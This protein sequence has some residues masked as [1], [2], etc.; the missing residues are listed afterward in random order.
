MEA[1]RQTNTSSRLCGVSVDNVHR[2][3]F[4]SLDFIRIYTGHPAACPSSAQTRPD[5]MDT[6]SNFALAPNALPTC[7]GARPLKSYKA[8]ERMFSLK[9]AM[10]DSSQLFRSTRY[11]GRPCVRSKY[12]LRNLIL[13][14]TL[15]LLEPSKSLRSMVDAFSLSSAQVPSIKRLSAHNLCGWSSRIRETSPGSRQSSTSSSKLSMSPSEETDDAEEWKAVMAAF[16][17]Y[18]AAYGDLK[19]PQRFVVPN[20]PPWPSVAWGLKLGK[21]VSA[22]RSTGRYMSDAS[23][24]TARRQV[25]DQ[26]GFVWSMRRSAADTAAE[27]QG[28]RLEQVIT[29]V[30]VYKSVM[31]SVANIPSNFVVPDAEAWPESVRG[32]PL[33]RQLDAIKRSKNEAVRE[34]FAALGI[35]MEDLVQEE[36]DDIIDVEEDEDNDVPPSP[37][38]PSTPADIARALEEASDGSPD[39]PSANDIRFQNVY[40]A[41]AIYKNL[42]DDLLVPQPFAVPRDPQWPADIWGLRLG[43]R[44]NA[45]RSQGTFVSN[46]SKRR[47]LLDDLGFV[48]SPPKERRRGRKPKDEIDMPFASDGLDF[49][50]D[51]FAVGATGSSTLDT[52]FDGSFDFGKDFDLPSDGEKSSPTWNLDGA[53]LPDINA[54]AASEQDTATKEDEYTEP[55][56]LAES[57]EEAT[58]RAIDCGIIEGLTPKKRVIKGKREKDIPWFNDDFGEYFVFEDVVEALSIYKSIYGDFLKLTNSNFVVPAPKEVTGFLDD[59]SLEIFDVDASARAAAAIASFEEQGQTERSEDF[60]AAEIKRL[61]REVDQPFEKETRTAVLEAEKFAGKWPEHLAGMALGSLVTRMRDGSLEV[62]HLPER[63]AQ[64]DA[65]GFEWGDPMYFIDVP[66]EKAMCAMYAYYLVRGDMFVLEDFIMPDEDP[67]PQALAGYEIGKAV[68]R[69]RQLQNFLEAY[70]SEKVSLLRMIDFVWFADTM[71]LP[72]DPNET[73]MTP[74]TLLLSAMGHPDFAKMIDIPMGLPDKLVADGPFLETDDDPKLWWRKWHNWDYVK[75]Y[76]YQQ[77]RRDNG[78]VLRAMGYPRMADEHE[79]KYGPG[80]FSQIDKVMADLD[81]GG[82]KGKSPDERKELLEQL[83]F[84]RQEMLGCTDIQPQDRDTLLADLDLQMLTIMKDANM[85]MAIADELDTAAF[86]H[87]SANGAEK[88]SRVLNKRID[89]EDEEDMEEEVDEEVIEEEEFDVEDELGLGGEPW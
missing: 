5:S 45:I 35:P 12:S 79:A 50:D 42:Y 3:S 64:L 23:S 86:K 18:K 88:K 55:R 89:T 75:D 53:R 22:I 17:M 19:V 69:L 62:K 27:D 46:N 67:W 77:G 70:H 38:P 66:F 24:R 36:F 8:E 1:E 28:I 2:E 60:I 37:S 57:L 4:S 84:F 40:T 29:G 26:L 31:G 10:E 16:K 58:V 21:V 72:L 81:N 6:P 32:L 74:E 15:L 30:K 20:M 68:T 13:I 34:K 65:I 43:A 87:E 61:Q 7:S 51:D 83:N 9:A 11:Y 76:W 59:D 63:K 82:I 44:V 33:G 25:L 71:A 47:K 52:L 73:E 14:A 48:W 54:K 39:G 78:Y 41:L 85:D 56:T 49:D 80:L